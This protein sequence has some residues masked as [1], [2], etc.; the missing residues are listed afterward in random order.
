MTTPET[1]HATLARTV[2]LVLAILATL[3]LTAPPVAGG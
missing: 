2:G 1:R 3:A